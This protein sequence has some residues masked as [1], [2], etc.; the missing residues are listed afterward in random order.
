MAIISRAGDFFYALRFLRLLTTPFNKTKAFELGIIDANGK[1]L[2]KS[3][4]LKDNDEKS[5]YTVFHRLVFN[6]KRL[7]GKAPGG[8]SALASYAAALFLIKEQTGMSEK[9]LMKAM[10][11]VLEADQLEELEESAWFQE[12]NRLNPG[13]Y[14]LTEDICSPIT[15][16]PLAMAKSKI[17]VDNQIEPIDRLFEQ[18]IYKVK[19]QLTNQEIYITNR[20]IKR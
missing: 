5:A 11:K 9:A 2:R 20:E 8:K 4:T 12:D 14:I 18:N 16:E 19:H 6:I 10:A 17:K 3:K 7:L 13:T 15:G 1:V